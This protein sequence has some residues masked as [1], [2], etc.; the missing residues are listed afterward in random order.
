MIR[1]QGKTCLRVTT[2]SPSIRRPCFLVVGDCTM[3]TNRMNGLRRH[4]V[5]S[6]SVYG[7]RKYDL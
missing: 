2:E 4:N 3:T 1:A 7:V 6:K 5:N